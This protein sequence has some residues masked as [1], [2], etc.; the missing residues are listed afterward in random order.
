MVSTFY[1][2]W[3]YPRHFRVGKEYGIVLTCDG[4]LC[5]SYWAIALDSASVIHS[6]KSE[7]HRE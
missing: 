4:I 7:R 1:I 5:S 3:D 6:G 2:G